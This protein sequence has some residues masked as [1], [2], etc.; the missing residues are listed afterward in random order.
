[1]ALGGLGQ[2]SMDHQHASAVLHVTSPVLLTAIETYV[3]PFLSVLAMFH[4]I[5]KDIICH[6]RLFPI[7]WIATSKEYISVEQS[8]P[9]IPK[10]IMINW[11]HSKQIDVHQAT[12]T[13]HQSWFDYSLDIKS[14]HV[15]NWLNYHIAIRHPLANIAIL[16]NTV[17]YY[18]QFLKTIF[19]IKSEARYAVCLTN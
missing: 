8:I 11:T 3:G 5:W 1:M 14:F 16:C 2:T 13:C 10:A 6:W 12:K 4:V 18:N 15:A 7:K 9:Q 19:T 17:I